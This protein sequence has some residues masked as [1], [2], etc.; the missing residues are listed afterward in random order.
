MGSVNKLIIPSL[1]VGLDDNQTS[2]I[3]G[4]VIDGRIFSEA[5]YSIY[6]TVATGNDGVTQYGASIA[7]YFEKEVDHNDGAEVGKVKEY[8][9]ASWDHISLASD[10]DHPD[11]QVK[12]VGLDGNCKDHNSYHNG[13][14][15]YIAPYYI[16]GDKLMQVVHSDGSLGSKTYTVNA[17]STD[18]TCTIVI[19]P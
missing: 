19:R 2:A 16:Q 1:D 15:I 14:T 3:D 18:Y 17:N 7:A 10:P 12:V 8:A 5:G 9:I 11:T 4:I 6:Y 13:E